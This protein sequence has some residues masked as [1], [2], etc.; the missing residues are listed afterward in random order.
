MKYKIFC[1]ILLIYFLYMC[2]QEQAPSTMWRSGDNLQDS[3]LSFVVWISGIDQAIRF[4][5]KYLY[6]LSHQISPLFKLLKICLLLFYVYSVFPEHICAL[7]V[8]L[9]LEE[10]QKS[11]PGPIELELQMVVSLLLGAGN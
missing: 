3:V 5:I 8:Y 10:S 11:T 7:H 9:V 1:S 2:V 4:G 6:P